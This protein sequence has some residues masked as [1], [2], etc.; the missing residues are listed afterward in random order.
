MAFESFLEES[1]PRSRPAR[2]L[3]LIASALGHAA[4]VLGAAALFL[5]PGVQA[6]LPRLVPVSLRLPAAPL[7]R[8]APPAPAVALALEP[9]VV[10]KPGITRP[11]RRR[12]RALLAESAPAVAAVSN[13]PVETAAAEDLAA[14]VEAPPA[15]AVAA[16]AAAPV[17]PPAVP[18][19]RPR[20]LPEALASSQKL[21]GEMPRLPAALAQ[22]GTSY[23]VLARVC[24]SEGGRVDSVSLERSAHPALDDQV[25]S[26]LPTWRYRPVQVAGRAI[27]F[28]TFVRFEFRAL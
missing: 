1:K 2:V 5:R 6:S 21:S 12:P 25:R 14:A 18:P 16:P 3:A 23:V 19:L 20:F 17:Q 9:A 8:V 26:L 7:P 11:V 28:C 22:S 13:A 10:E 4:L 27:P 15:T 24:V